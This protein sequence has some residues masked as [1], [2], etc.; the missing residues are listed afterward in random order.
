MRFDKLTTRS[1]EAL[2]EAESRASRAGHPE[3]RP[4]H[5]LLALL[6]QKEGAVPAV[7]EVAKVDVGRLRAAIDARLARLPKVSGARQLVLSPALSRVLEQSF[8]EAER[9]QDEFVSTEHFLLAML[10][11][12]APSEAGEILRAQGATPESVYHALLQVRGGETVTSAAPEETYQ[13]LTK[14]T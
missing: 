2:G 13:A 4:E 10:D 8:V 1:Q 11:V 5:L 14:Y 9:L 12:S 6:E 3:V 7:L